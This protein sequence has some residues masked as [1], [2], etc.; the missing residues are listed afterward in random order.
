VQWSYDL[1]DDAERTLLQQCSVFSGGFDLAGAQ[2]ISGSGDEFATLDV[3]HALVRKSLLVADRSAQRTRFSMLET[4][5]QFA[6][7]QL[8]L[9]GEAEETR[10]AHARYFATCED[11]V[12]ALFDGPRQREAYSWVTVELPNLRTAFR[13]AI[14][15]DDLDT[16]TA[17][18]HYSAVVGF[19][20]QQHEPVRWAEELI[21]PARAVQHRR[22]AQLYSMATMCFTAG[23][24]E[25]ANRYAEAGQ[26]AILSGR[27]DEVRTDAEASIGSSFSASGEVD[28]W[29]DWVRVVLKRRPAAYIHA[30]AILVLALKMA[31]AEDES[32]SASEELLIAADAA[33]N[34]NL[35]AWALFAYGGAQRDVNPAGAYHALRRGLTI[36]NDSGS[37]QTRSSIASM[38]A[39]LAI[40]HGS[41]TDALDYVTLSLRHYYDSG[42][43]WLVKS[44][45]SVLVVLFDQLGHHEPAAV[46]SGFA[47]N[48]F[49]LSALPA[50]GTAVTHLREVLGDEVYESLAHTGEHMTN[51]EMVQYAFEQI[52]L[53]R[54][55]LSSRTADA[56]A[57]RTRP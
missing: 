24:I 36:A 22:L 40:T 10:H 27:F 48:D 42:N 15:W 54:A 47:V 7:E 4:I 6:E 14:E 8:A 41:P 18:V 26:A 13:W 20:G 37:G 38:L 55:E 49:T 50:I 2:A 56:S 11:D 21:E 39:P 46:A 31:G 57:R 52:E 32:V 43:F 51:A 3:L 5:R 34:P 53:A 19:W 9:T 45:L 30:Q 28:R 35:T 29:V 1:L 44:P 12:L 33:G 25:D 23:R 16:A 17:I